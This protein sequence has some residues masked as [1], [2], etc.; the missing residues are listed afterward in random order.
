MSTDERLALRQIE[1]QL[2]A[3]FGG[4][5]M[6]LHP[7]RGDAEI[8][9]EFRSA[10]HTLVIEYKGRSDAAGVAAAISQLRRIRPKARDVSVIAVPFMGATGAQLCRT[11]GMSWID[12]AGNA[13]ITGPGLHI[14]IEGHANPSKPLGRPRN[15]FA[16]KSAR[17]ARFLLTHRTRSYP[18]RRI[19]VETGLDEGLV[20]RVVRGLEHDGL[21]VRGDDGGVRVREAGLV[22]DAW[23]ESY[24][25]EHHA[26]LRGHVPVRSSESGLRAIADALHAGM[27][28]AATGLGA[29]WLHTG[30]GG[31]RLLTF[32]VEE[33]PPTALLESLDFRETERGANVW[34]V[35]PDDAGVFDNVVIQHDVRCA[36]PVQ[37]YL[38]LKAHPER[39]EEASAKVRD[40]I[41]GGTD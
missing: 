32:F 33:L 7:R 25:F 2:S 17:V 22:L 10:D 35:V 41:L 8:D 19:A 13:H 9:A 18:Q 27:L 15:L 12:L 4:G 23:R 6:R 30:F 26:I 16:P 24:D 3:I 37:V 20:S 28:A 40:L 31:F 11:A 21:V 36:H 14:Q 29:A 5:E 34:L 1:T 38:D 39:A